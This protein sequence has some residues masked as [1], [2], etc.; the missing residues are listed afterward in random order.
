MKQVY[1]IKWLVAVK[2]GEKVV[3]GGEKIAQQFR[4]LGINNSFQRPKAVT[5]SGTHIQYRLLQ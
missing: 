1:Q 5:R 2:K 3:G 4:V